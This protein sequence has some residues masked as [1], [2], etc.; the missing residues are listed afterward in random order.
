MLGQ[1]F[2][3]ALAA[4]GANAT[5]QEAYKVHAA[6]FPAASTGFSGQAT[7]W[8]GTAA[9][10]GKGTVQNDGKPVVVIHA[11]GSMKQQ[12][13]RYITANQKTSVLFDPRLKIP[14]YLAQDITFVPRMTTNHYTVELKLTNFSTTPVNE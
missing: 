4:G 10:T 6:F 8:N 12:G 9:L 1:H 11:T 7:N 13:G 2:F 5:W 14:V 3:K